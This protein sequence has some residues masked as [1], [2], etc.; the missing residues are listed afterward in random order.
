MLKVH[1]AGK[2]DAGDVEAADCCYKRRYR[3]YDLSVVDEEK[4]MFR[5]RR[6]KAV[7][8]VFL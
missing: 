3:S 4:F 8:A 6:S 5:K 1:N 2:G 7:S